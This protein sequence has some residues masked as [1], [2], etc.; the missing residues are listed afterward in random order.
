MDN[1]RMY[2]PRGKVLGGSSSINAMCFT[3]GA[4]ADFDRWSESGVTGWAW[5][6]MLPHFKATQQQLRPDMDT[7]WHGYHGEQTVADT[8]H[9]VNELSHDFIEAV[10]QSGAAVKNNDFSGAE[11]EGVGLYQTYQNGRAQRVSAAAAFLHP[12]RDRSNLTV[13][14]RAQVEKVLFDKKA[15]TG[16][17]CFVSGKP[18]KISASREVVLSAGAINSPQLLMLSGIGDSEE[19]TQHQVETVH[20]LP[21]VGKNLHDHLDIILNTRVTGFKGIG[22]SLPF[23]FKGAAQLV[24]YFTSR[25][26]FLTCNGA[27]AGGFLKTDPALAIPDVQMHFAPLMLESHFLRSLGHGHSLHLCNLQ[28][29]S[30]GWVQL[31][32]TKPNDKPRIRF[33]YGEHPDDIDVLVKAV[34]IGRKIL[35]QP[36]LLQSQKCEYTPGESV[37]TDKQIREFIRQKAETIYHPVGTCSMGAGDKA[38]VD[39]RL[40]VYGVDRLRVIDASVVPTINSGNTHSVVIAI[41]NKAAEMIVQGY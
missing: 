41:A 26:G 20:H 2:C 21:G 4:P 16:V 35:S 38:V 7:D 17:Q 19:L 29:K 9:T 13:V 22:F 31:R 8:H 18:V 34:K 11:L 33:N 6:D 5:Q 40:R 1:R 32:S 25:K 28:P 36:A 23:M 14:T 10:T 39:E 24:Q 27:E 3:R 15:A 30:R 12:I 37:Q